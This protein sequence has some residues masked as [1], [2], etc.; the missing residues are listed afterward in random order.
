MHCRRASQRHQPASAP[1][2]PD[3]G[4]RPQPE[5]PPA[6][7]RRRGQL[8]V[9]QQTGIRVDVRRMATAAWYNL[10]PS[11]TTAIS[12]ANGFGRWHP[13]WLPFAGAADFHGVV[14]RQFE[15]L[16]ALTPPACATPSPRLAARAGG[17]S[18]LTP[19]HAFPLR[20]MRPD[21]VVVPRIAL[22]GDAAHPHPLARVRASTWALATPTP[23]PAGR[24]RRRPRRIIAAAPLPAH[25]PRVW[26]TPCS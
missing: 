24:T 10:S 13:G 17:F 16:T 12:P 4:R 22:V 14:H 11:A 3:A 5:H 9:R 20:L 19:A 23:T 8:L 15:A 21:S 26:S 1:C 25:A 7:W 2:Q 6:D 18:L